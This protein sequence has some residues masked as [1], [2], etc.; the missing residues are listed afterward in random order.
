MAALDLVVGSRTVVQSAPVSDCDNKAKT[1]LTSVLQNA[2]E[3]G[4][5]THEWFAHGASDANGQFTSAAAVNCFPV[6]TGY[7]VTITCTAE[8]PPNPQTAADICNKIST[9]FGATA[10]P[11]GGSK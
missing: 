5:G 10:A 8:I 1:S 9:A 6:G 4:D 2:T 11:A 3:A 7:V